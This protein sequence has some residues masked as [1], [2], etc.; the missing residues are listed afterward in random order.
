VQLVELTGA[1]RLDADGNVLKIFLALLRGDY[2]LV[3][4]LSGSL[5]RSRRRMCHCRGRRL[6]R[7]GW[8]S[9]VR[10]RKGR[11][12]DRRRREKPEGKSPNCPYGH[13]CPQST[14]VSA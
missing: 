10:L 1:D 2:D 5:G 8:L 12:C 13:D 6:V 14:N 4:I 3:T 7:G 9:R 11:R